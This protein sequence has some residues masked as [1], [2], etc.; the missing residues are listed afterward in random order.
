MTIE[1]F[2]QILEQRELVPLKIVEQVRTKVEKGDR[3]I[4]PKSLLKYLV[5]KELVTRRQ[6]KQLLETTLTVSP[7]AESSILGMVPIPKVP[8]EDQPSSQPTEAEIP[9]ILPVDEGSGSSVTDGGS[10]DTFDVFSEKPSSLL[11]DSLS[12]IG[13]GDPGIAAA[14][15]E[16]KLDSPGDPAKQRRKKKKANK[17]E[18][19]SSLLLL[20]GGGLALLI[21][22]LVI[23]GYL[24]SRESADEVLALASEHFDGGSY[25]QAI[26]QYERFVENHSGHPEFSAAKVKLGM[27]RLWKVSSGTS[28]FTGALQIAQ[29]V[30]D[31]IGDESEFNSAQRDLAS[32]L[33][34]IAQGLANQA[35]KT[36]ESDKAEPDKI[37]QLIEQVNTSLAI[38]SNT[39][40]IP[41]TFRDEVLLSEVSQTLDRVKRSQVERVSLTQ[42]LTD[43]QT[44]LASSKTAE[45]YQIHAQLL[46]EHPGL[47]NNEQLA[48]K[49][50]EISAAE[51]SVV[52]YIAQPQ[53]ATTT[54]RPT[55]VLAEL[56]LAN[57][58]GKAA[59]TDEG[60]VAVRVG[61]AVYGLNIRD[62][63]LLWRRFV[64]IA[65]KLTPLTL[66]S[67]DLLVVD[68]QHNELLKLSGQTGKLLWR[69]QFETA[70]SRPVLLGEQALVAESAGKLHVVEISTGERNGYVQ[71]AQQL[72]TPP[73]LDAQGR[74]IYITGEHSSLYTLSTQDFSCLGVFFLN[75]AQGSVTTPPI[76]VLNKVVVAVTKGLSTSH[77]EVINTTDD[78]VPDQKVTSR[79]LKGVVNTPLLSQGRRLVALTSRGQ[80][81]VYEVGAGADDSALTKIANRAPDT[82]DTVARFGLLGKGHVWMAGTQLLKLTILPTSDRLPVSTLDHD[83]L[84]D[85]FD[86]PLQTRGNLLIHVRRPAGKA[87][88]I[89]AA[90]ATE[91]GQSQWETELAV[92]LAG[93]PAADTAGMQIGA[94][95][96]SGAAY[97]LDRQTMSG[98]VQDEAA[99]LASNRRKLP[100]LN[101]AIDLGEGRLVASAI[102]AQTLL[103]FRPGLPRG[104]LKT[105]KLVGPLSCPPVLWEDAF[106][107][108]TSTGQVFLYAIDSGQQLGS[109]FQ[110]AL[111]P[112]VT[113]NWQSPAVYDNGTG[114]DSQLILSD[115]KNSV[116]LLSRA[117]TPQPHLVA[118]AEV[119]IRTSPLSTRFAVLGDLA[120]AGTSD[121]NLA[122]YELPTL[123]DRPAPQLNAQITWGPFTVGQHIV[124][125][126]ATEEFVCLDDQAK[127]IW[128]QPLAHGPPTGLPILHNGAL[129]LLWQQGGLS[130]LQLSDGS[131]AAYVPLPQPAIA[132][133]VPFG[134]R[135]VVSSYD[136]TLLIVDPP[137]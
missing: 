7:N 28:N 129:V 127:I 25:T 70:V 58:S 111:A 123:S 136:G 39:K 31:D 77:L 87:G 18:W 47:I 71:F 56:T 73:A 3:R 109:P 116:Y 78:G 69:Q 37:E 17:N 96:A 119:A 76:N 131:E 122:I 42:S 38:C 80:V 130:R 101:H 49:V 82:G 93:P 74:R 97:L 32:L 36:A 46:D 99:Q 88:A 121:G 45:A 107:A 95:S 12:K 41:K 92:P 64:G 113:Y 72:P 9:T 128:R 120:V 79:R 14:L 24:L 114:N 68:D 81:T 83:Y 75:H 84:G 33:P 100:S 10:P 59:S 1:D 29:E 5:K 94:V 15:E 21:I 52:K 89:V 85:T 44:A 134:K 55:K 126:T 86:H 61:G 117:T 13:V 23:I 102:D 63:S 124:F 19:D 27:A 43:M 104:A 137:Q 112:G 118:T 91:T 50:L 54:P 105:I 2:L 66:P 60:T 57:R 125:A 20:G 53:A 8:R 35:E 90:I 110:P 135:L 48:A 16:N 30:L 51:S 26:K 132:G 106:V 34:K 22:T 98:R 65:P 108:P 115:S 62:G 67:G 4:T 11:A 133:P 103:H 6:A 40:Y